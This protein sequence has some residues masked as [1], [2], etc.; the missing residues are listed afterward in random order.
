MPAEFRGDRVIALS[1][2]VWGRNL[3]AIGLL[4]LAF[5]APVLLWAWSG[6]RGEGLWL[7]VAL[8][9]LLEG[10]FRAAVSFAVDGRL[11]GGAFP[12]LGGVRAL[13]RRIAVVVGATAVPALAVGLSALP[14]VWALWTWWPLVLL[15]GLLP[16]GVACTFS[17]AVPAAVL[18]RRGVA[19]T[20]ARSVDLTRGRRLGI[21]VV[22]LVVGLAGAALDGILGVA[23]PSAMA[24]RAHLVVAF[25]TAT[26]AAV[27]TGVLYAELVGR[28]S[29]SS[30]SR[31]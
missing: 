3:G 15:L 4:G 27:T 12:A 6:V 10:C 8:A 26:L 1:F 17:V 14:A 9:A 7:L 23:L 20:L 29:S 2:R 11:R 22:F 31:A 13:L 5:F 16:L 24:I 25:L 18:E 21:L 28:E 19:L 30:A